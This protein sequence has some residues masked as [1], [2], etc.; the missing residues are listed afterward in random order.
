M[1]STDHDGVKCITQDLSSVVSF[2]NQ[3]PSLKDDFLKTCEGENGPDIKML[4]G[5]WPER[6]IARYI[7]N[8]NKYTI[9]ASVL[10]E[11]GIDDNAVI[12]EFIQYAKTYGMDIKNECLVII[13]VLSGIEE[14]LKKINSPERQ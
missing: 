4:M 8:L 9:G 3:Y 10:R 6:V 11:I 2:L 7:L 14:L 12:K 5:S 13:D 1:L